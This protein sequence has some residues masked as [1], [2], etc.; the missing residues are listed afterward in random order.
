MWLIGIQSFPEAQSEVF[1]YIP[2]KDFLGEDKMAFDVTVNG[3]KF[4]VS[5]VMKVVQAH[6]FNDA[7]V[8]PNEPGSDDQEVWNPI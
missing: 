5:I 1:L 6:E 3:Q 8:D 2:D 4:R 7:C